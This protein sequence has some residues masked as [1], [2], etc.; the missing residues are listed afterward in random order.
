MGNTEGL[1]GL[2]PNR[3]Q[4]CSLRQKE[5]EIKQ[6]T[7]KYSDNYAKLQDLSVV[8]DDNTLLAELNHNSNIPDL[9]V[10]SMN[11]TIRGMG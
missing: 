10:S 11:A 5:F 2:H 3:H 8:L 1:R 4:V 7:V 9:N 6:I